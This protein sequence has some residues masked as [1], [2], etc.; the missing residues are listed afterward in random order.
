MKSGVFYHWRNQWQQQ[1]RLAQ[2]VI[3]SALLLII[4]AYAPTLQFDYV[5][6]DQWRAFR[7]GLDADTA[8]SRAKQCWHMIPTFYT[9]TGRPLAWLGECVEHGVVAT[10]ADFKF[11]R[12]FMLGVV[13]A[14]VLYV[15]RVLTPMLGGLAYGVIAASL[16]VLAPGYSFMYFQAFPALPVLLSVMLAATSFTMLP[17]TPSYTVRPL[18]MPLLSF[19]AACCIYPAYAFSALVFILLDFAKKDDA[20]LKDR[21]LLA[22]WRVGFYAA[23][24]VVY[25]LFVKIMVLALQLYLGSLPDLQNYEVSAQLTPS[26]LFLKLKI[27]AI[28]FFH[29]SPLNGD[30]P[31]G[32]TVFLAIG[33]SLIAAHEA[34]RRV[35]N[36]TGLKKIGIYSL[37]IVAVIATALAA[38]GPW[39]LSKMD[40][41]STR[42]VLGWY[43]LFSVM[44]VWIAKWLVERFS[45]IRNYVPLIVLII[46]LLPCAIIQYRLSGLEIKT[47]N[48]EIDIFRERL[49]EWVQ[50]RGW[51]NNRYLLVLAPKITRAEEIEAEVNTRPWGND[52][53]VLATA[54]NPVSIPWMVTAVLREEMSKMDFHLVDCADDTGCAGAAIQEPKTV[55]VGYT[56][57][58]KPMDAPVA[59]FIINVAQLTWAPIHPTITIKQVPSVK[60]S[61]TLDEL[62]PYG[63]LRALEPGWHAARAPH[64]PQTLN[65]DFVE[66]KTFHQIG[67][68]PQD[69]HAARMPKT[70]AV[71][72]S[73]DGMHWQTMEKITNACEVEAVDHW[74]EISLKKPLTTRYLQLEVQDNCGDADFLT[75]RGLRVE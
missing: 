49:H 56:Y 34:I 59:P 42:H 41:L 40:Y 5:T 73:A 17:R 65:V 35:P 24:A 12:P 33:F 62:G 39:L 75:L 51:E 22:L 7:Y 58:N 4:F 28:Y 45:K 43:F 6:Q 20:V 21:T 29:M 32:I 13:L 67:F 14:T 61:S 71:K 74:H 66:S 30:W 1:S 44:A 23:A 11:L 70:V 55:V 26:F 64:Y 3:W 60:A 19:L 27:A 53:A 36:V 37:F 63:L 54:T 48:L 15:G 2:C 69:G 18:I 57:T 68:L 72:I 9:Q 31:S 38:L 16:L 47:T 25:Y 10:I 46:T 52:N 8:L 50:K